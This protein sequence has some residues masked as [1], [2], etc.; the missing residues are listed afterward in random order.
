MREDF[1]ATEIRGAR[2]G[3]RVFQNVKPQAVRARW[4]KFLEWVDIK[5]KL[6][7]IKIGAP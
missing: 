3:G 1:C 4:I 7:L 6:N 5:N 2:L